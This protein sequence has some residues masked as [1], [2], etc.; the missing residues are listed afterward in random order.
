VRDGSLVA[1]GTTGRH[2]A[3]SLPD[4]QTFLETGESRLASDGWYGIFTTARTPRPVIER[5][6]AETQAF[7]RDPRVAARFQE[8]GMEA[9][10]STPEQLGQALRDLTADFTTLA[11]ELN[12][13]TPAG[14]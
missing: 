9:Q 14:R 4:V 1:L 3:P 12:A 13:A 11:A 6:A 2:R 10:G 8:A 7:T 5:L